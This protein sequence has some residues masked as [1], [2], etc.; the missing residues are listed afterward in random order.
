MVV[1]FLRLNQRKE[2]VLAKLKRID[3]VGSILFTG[4]LT[5]ALLGIT[6]GGVMYPWKSARTLVPMLVGVIG[7]VVFMLFEWYTARQGRNTII[8]IDIFR[9]TTACANFYNTFI[10]GVCMWLGLYYLPLY[11]EGIK[12]FGPVHAGLALFPIT[13]TVVPVSIITSAIIKRT[14]KYRWGQWIGW[15]IL[16]ISSGLKYTFD[17]QTSEAQW[18]VYT[19]LG[20]IGLGIVLPT[21][22]ITNMAAAP[23]KH[24]ATAAGMVP[25][26]RSFGQTMGVALGGA[27]FQ[28]C[29]KEEI[30][31]VPGL[32]EVVGRFANDATAVVEFLKTLPDSPIK[33]TTKTAFAR[34]LQPVWMFQLGIAASAFLAGL[35]VRGYT[36]DRKPVTDHGW[37]GKGITVQVGTIKKERSRNGST[38]STYTNS[39]LVAK[40]HLKARNA[41]YT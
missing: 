20:G 1:L 22:A 3:Y 15:P 2:N 4:S 11:Y 26:F 32:T 31:K 41:G 34:G 33:S 36:M 17:V 14:Q 9:T 5:S 38:D 6:W 8:T 10:H 37:L 21:L 27:I 16:V 25:F 40:V 7:L 35:L 12:E 23:N 28:N 18:I 19:T 30:N 29:F 39:V 24:I 13:M